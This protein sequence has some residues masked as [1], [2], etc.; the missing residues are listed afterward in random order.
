M[1]RSGTGVC[2]KTGWRLQGP[3]RVEDM[4]DV[5]HISKVQAKPRKTIGVSL[6]IAQ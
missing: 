2:K 3:G 4:R 5:E 1:E 6:R